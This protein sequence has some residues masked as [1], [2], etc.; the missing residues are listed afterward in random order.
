VSRCPVEGREATLVPD[1]SFRCYGFEVF[2]A[3]DELLGFGVS[4][5]EA[6]ISLIQP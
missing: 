3:L 1:Q 5:A 2:P 4:Y 6:L